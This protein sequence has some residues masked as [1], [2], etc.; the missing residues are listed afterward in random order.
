MPDARPPG[1][2]GSVGGMAVITAGKKEGAWRI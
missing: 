1:S 2:M